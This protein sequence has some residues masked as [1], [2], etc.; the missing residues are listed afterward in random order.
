M[1]TITNNAGYFYWLEVRFFENMA[2]KIELY[3]GLNI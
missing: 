3:A 2:N 1:I